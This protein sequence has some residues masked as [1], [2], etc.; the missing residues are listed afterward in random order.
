MKYL[1]PFL[2]IILILNISCNQNVDIEK[3]KKELMNA[4]LEF[5][6]LS[7]DKG[8]N[9]AFSEYIHPDG[10]LLRS[11]GMP[12][13]GKAT[14]DS[15]QQLS[16][17]TGYTLKWK[18]LYVDASQSGEIGYTYGIWQM[19]TK[20]TSMMGTYAT[21]WKKDSNGRWKFILDTGN[22]GLGKDEAKEKANF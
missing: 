13:K 22:D 7:V 10:V 5:S 20:D 11:N 19:S 16:P 18:P 12:L 4:D 8:K 9:L 14:L 3:V 2:S 17:D 15:M 1:L 6:K 21:V